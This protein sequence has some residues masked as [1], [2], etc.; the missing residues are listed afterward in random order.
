MAAAPAAAG[1]AEAYQAERRP[2]NM[3]QAARCARGGPGCAPTSAHK[4]ARAHAAGPTQEAQR[5]LGII[6]ALMIN[7]SD[8]PI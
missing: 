1:N 4:P 2:V 5:N 6:K 3:P 8:C 7:L